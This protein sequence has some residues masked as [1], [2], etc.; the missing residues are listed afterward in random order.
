MS[1]M[2]DRVVVDLGSAFY[3]EF[4]HDESFNKLLY[5]YQPSRYYG[6]DPSSI[7]QATD[8]DFAGAHCRFERKAAWVFNGTLALIEAPVVAN[9]LRTF[10]APMDYP[11]QVPCFDI[12]EFLETLAS[13][14][15][16]LKMDVEGAEYTLIPYLKATGADALVSELLVEWHRKPL[17]LE[18]ACG[19]S[20]W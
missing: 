16:I 9:S 3:P 7:A 20:P 2:P 19:V 6:F 10:V 1:F 5:K 15:V 14:H 17:N 13:D 11:T 4:P 8:F 12:A 18:L